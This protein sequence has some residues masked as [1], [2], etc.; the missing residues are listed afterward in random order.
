MRIKRM[1]EQC[2]RTD[3]RVAQEAL[4][5]YFFII[6]LTGDPV[7]PSMVTSKGSS[8]LTIVTTLISRPS[9]FVSGMAASAAWSLLSMPAPRGEV[10]AADFRRA[11]RGDFSGSLL[12]S[13]GFR[14]SG[15]WSGA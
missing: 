1:S 11:L 13:L 15:V 14:L 2:E 9:M 8:P 7:P 6:W 12:L 10:V 3:E 4:R 5:V